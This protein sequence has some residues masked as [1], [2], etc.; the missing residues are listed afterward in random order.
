MKAKCHLTNFRL[1]E[2]KR[3][4]ST[5]CTTTKPDWSRPP[6]GGLRVVVKALV[7]LKS[8]S[9][10]TYITGCYGSDS[11]TYKDIEKNKKT[12]RSLK[13]FM[14]AAARDAMERYLLSLFGKR[15]GLKPQKGY[16]KFVDIMEEK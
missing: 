14:V 5:I 2:I 1:Y 16:F 6:D 15:V 4:I 13:A 12:M 9:G 10:K 3:K 11:M 7:I 8:I